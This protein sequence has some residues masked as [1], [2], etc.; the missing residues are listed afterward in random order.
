MN[1]NTSFRRVARPVIVVFFCALPF[2][3]PVS[4]PAAVPSGEL[5]DQER[6]TGDLE[7]LQQVLDELRRHKIPVNTADTDR[8]RELPWLTSGD[9]LSIIR[10]QQSEGPFV[11]LQQLE[12]ILGREKATALAPYITFDTP[13][14]AL[15]SGKKKRREERP[16]GSFY[17]RVFRETT[18]R[19][20]LYDGRYGGEN[21][22]LSN[23]LQ[24]D[25]ANCRF[26]LVHERD[27]G[28][29][30]FADFLSLS[31]ALSDLGI[32]KQAVAGNYELNFGQ[33]LLLG[34]SRFLSKGSEPSNSVRLGSKRLAPYGS[35]SEYGFFQGVATTVA[36][37]PFEVTAFYSA[38][39][40]DA[41]KVNG[42]ITGFDESGYHRSR[43][44]RNRKDNVTE[45]VYGANVLYRFMS[46]TVTGKAGGTWLRYDY[47]DP[48]RSLDGRDASLLGSVE[49]DVTVGKLGLFGEAA[50]SEKPD[51]RISW[52]AGADYP[53]L[54][55]VHFLAALRDYDTRYYSPFAGAF[56]ERAKNATNEKGVYAGIDAKI[57]SDF[58][59]GAYYDWFR[60]PLLGE[61][62][63]FASDG[64]DIRL[65]AD[66]RQSE[67]ISWSLQYQHKYKERQKK[68]GSSSEPLWTALPQV[69]DRFRL[70]C[71][72]DL[73]RN[74]RLRTRGE[75][76][77]VVSEYLR[78]DETAHGWLLYQQAA[79]AAGG[80]SLK[81]RFTLFNTDSHD[82]AIY[83][84]E[85]DLPFVFNTRAFNGRGR[86]LFLAASWSV[87]RNLKLAGKFETT[88]YSGRDSYGSGP[89]RRA[90]SAPG[91]FHLG[92]FLNF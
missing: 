44:E 34:Q 46:G 61:H 26:Y 4:V 69:T 85:D 54:P 67:T 66:Y 25:Y 82:A 18:A 89:D 49:A 70:D 65:F 36:L 81:G 43:T 56:A 14:S 55:N 40:V 88:W 48:L 15:P 21:F 91:S 29:P 80:L 53:I 6:F 79:Y 33:G 64:Y 62:A 9:I 1:N 73:S 47:G 42:V 58:S 8:L 31:F 76:K 16:G 72:I 77:R 17:S 5:F 63:R 51:S 19:E 84:Y 20:G 59:V 24:L 41:R 3:H 27:I 57:S 39:R 86:A 75:V 71:T 22:K 45:T 23:R 28:E 60:F 68:Q 74:L 83:A 35:S 2:L 32:I 37:F 78:G 90:T 11:S 12:V 10:H 52:I 50:W 87:M 7:R 13:D 38:N 30:D 92:C